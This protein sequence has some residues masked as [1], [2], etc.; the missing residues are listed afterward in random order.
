MWHPTT[1]WR[2]TDTLYSSSHYDLTL[3]WH[4]AALWSF[5]RVHEEEYRDKEMAR[6]SESR[7][8][9]GQEDTQ[10]YDDSSMKNPTV[11]S[12][13]YEER[14]ERDYDHRR[15][16]DDRRSDYNDRR[17]DYDDRRSDYDDRRS[18]YDDRRSDYDD[19]RDRYS[20][21]NERYDDRYDEPYDDRERAPASK[22]RRRDYDDWS[23]QSVSTIIFHVLF[24]L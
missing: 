5:Y 22:P 20:D 14:S 12:E 11:R 1:K 10:G 23:L 7:R 18:D 21:R 15:D 9:D 8:A 17:S 19:R 2:Q 16:Y 24:Y 3:L 4:L 6:N 13:R